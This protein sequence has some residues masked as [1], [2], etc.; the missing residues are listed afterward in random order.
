MWWREGNAKVVER[1]L[2]VM[3]CEGNMGE[4]RRDLARLGVRPAR[5]FRRGRAL[6]CEQ[7]RRYEL[8]DRC[9]TGRAF[10]SSSDC[11]SCFI[12]KTSSSSG[13]PPL[14]ILSAS[15]LASVGMYVAVRH[16]LLATVQSKR[17]CSKGRRC[18]DF[19]PQEFM[20]WQTVELSDRMFTI[21]CC[22]SVVKCTH[23]SVTAMSSFLLMLCVSSC[24]CR[25]R[26]YVGMCG[27]EMN[28]AA[29]AMS[30]ASVAM[31]FKSKCWN[32]PGMGRS[33]LSARKL[34]HQCSSDRCDND[35]VTRALESQP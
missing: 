9:H 12:P 29:I 8:C 16:T 22:T 20:Q 23:D 2:E 18:L 13:S 14:D 28:A 31:N 33:F 5:R 7:A 15:L 34:T 24:F 26:R 10:S 30:L 1:A 32:C 25:Y 4:D 11:T 17:D 19:V 3:R 21:E 27:C 35:R 6:S